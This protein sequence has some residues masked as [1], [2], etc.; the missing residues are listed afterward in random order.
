MQTVAELVRQVQPGPGDPVSSGGAELAEILEGVRAL[1]DEVRAADDRSAV[2]H[3]LAA[4]VGAFVS[5]YLCPM[6]V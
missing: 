5:I 1:R 3:S 4:K 6:F 2:L